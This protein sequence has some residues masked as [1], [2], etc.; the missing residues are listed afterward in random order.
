MV[1]HSAV[2]LS[3]FAIR[4]SQLSYTD[5]LVPLRFRTMF[6]IFAC[7]KISR[8]HKKVLHCIRALSAGVPPVKLIL[9]VTT[10]KDD[11]FRFQV[12]PFMS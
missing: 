3:K 4:I 2:T 1:S 7:P 10:V 11:V 8:D 9:T 12:N 5:V 6:A